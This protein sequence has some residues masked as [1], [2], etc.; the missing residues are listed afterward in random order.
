MNIT[1]RTQRALSI[2][3]DVSL[4]FLQGAVAGLNEDYV[5]TYN[6][7]FTKA[8]KLTLESCGYNSFYDAY[9]DLWLSRTEEVSK[10]GEKDLSKLNATKRTVIR[11]GKPVEITVYTKDGEEPDKNNN[12]GG[13]DNSGGL[14]H[15]KQFKSSTETSDKK[16]QQVAKEL[17][18]KN[19]TSY[20][21]KK[22]MTFYMVLRDD[23][24]NAVAIIGYKRFGHYLKMVFFQSNG[25]I[26][27]TGARGFFEM[28][29]YCLQNKLGIKLDKTMGSSPFI[30][31]YNM[32]EDSRG[33]F[34]LGYE[35]LLKVFGEV[36][37]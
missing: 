1:E 17:S 7:E 27:G 20:T 3:E 35:D 33:D 32:Q 29:K 6:D 16:A 5:M 9:L 26:D 23:K 4:W 22:T 34:F 18:T 36:S 8:H 2:G 25:E 31:M 24:G 19:G 15:A 13:S 37:E 21:F 14:P 12:S 28:A 11:N 10:G 30:A